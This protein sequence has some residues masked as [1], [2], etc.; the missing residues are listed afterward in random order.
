MDC[1]L[2]L[3]EKNHTDLVTGNQ[4]ILKQQYVNYL[5]FFKLKLFT[6]YIY[7]LSISIEILALM[8]PW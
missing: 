7:S 4:L 1:P 3:F 5:N 8:G 2:F 6:L